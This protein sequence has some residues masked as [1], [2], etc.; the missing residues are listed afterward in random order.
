MFAIINQSIERE[1][2]LRRERERERKRERERE[3]SVGSLLDVSLTSK[4]LFSFDFGS[5]YL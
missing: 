1:V 3:R 5:A 4:E 2:R